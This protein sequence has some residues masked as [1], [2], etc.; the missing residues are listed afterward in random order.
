MRLKQ[1]DSVRPLTTNLFGFLL[2]CTTPEMKVMLLF[3]VT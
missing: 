3:L 1:S 2:L